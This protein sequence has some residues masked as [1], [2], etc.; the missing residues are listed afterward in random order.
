MIRK[1]KANK[2]YVLLLLFLIAL[3]FV[4]PTG[5]SQTCLNAVSVWATKIFPL[6]F[7]FF[8]LSRLI[9]NLGF[10]CDGKM[11]KLF[12]KCY[13]SPNISLKIFLLSTLS[14]YPMGAKLI[15]NLYESK[16]IN[17]NDAKK[18]LS[19]CSI[20]GPMFIIGSVG[21]GFFSCYKCG[22]VILVANI[23]AALINGQIFKGKA[24]DNNH[25]EHSISHTSFND[26]IYDSLISILMIGAY[27]VISF[28]FLEML[29]NFGL[30]DTISSL[31]SYLFKFDKQTV[32]SVI[33]GL[34]EITK[35]ISS[36]AITNSN[37]ILKTILASGLIGFGGF[38]IILQNLS[39][40]TKCDITIKEILKQKIVQGLISTLIAIP[41]AMLLL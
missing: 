19:Y 12:A 1:L 33:F 6:L 28:I 38:C 10:E 32:S 35:G 17:K 20:S 18:M 5:Y 14:G 26:I 3:F 4:N 24:T 16:S 34:F 15:S 40:I 23:I 21:V 31:F 36:L 39:F 25:L 13:N 9:L 41:L 8:M 11:D 27:I 2:I 30:I 37:L 29:K 22:I 7:P